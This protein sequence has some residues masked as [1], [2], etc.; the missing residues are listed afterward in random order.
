MRL[1][2]PPEDERP[3]AAEPPNALNRSTILGCARALRRFR[4]DHHARVGV[5]SI[6]T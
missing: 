6:L 5:E 2:C 3:L 4:T 1:G